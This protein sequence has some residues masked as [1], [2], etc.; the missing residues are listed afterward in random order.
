MAQQLKSIEIL[1]KVCSGTFSL[2]P[3]WLE[4]NVTGGI[5]LD[6]PLIIEY[7]ELGKHYTIRSQ[8]VSQIASLCTLS[9]VTPL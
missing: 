5:T 1:E 4:I 9:Q 8:T 2:E 6:G 7:T 3:K